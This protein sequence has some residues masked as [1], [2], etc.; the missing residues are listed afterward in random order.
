[1]HLRTSEAGRRFIGQWEG[2][3]L[4]RYLDVVG[5]PT[6]GYGHLC[7]P[8]DGLEAISEARADE[9]LSADLALAETAV[10]GLGVELGQNQFDALVSFAFNLGGGMLGQSHTIGQALRAGDF[11]AA[12]ASFVLYDHAG[13]REDQ[14]LRNRRLSERELFERPEPVDDCPAT[15]PGA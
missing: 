13:G 12:A 11:A 7:Q 9:L 1:M 10:N 3:R 6:I 15:D 14:G 4:H 8:G 5:K 2:L